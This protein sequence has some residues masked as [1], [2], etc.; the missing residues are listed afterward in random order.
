MSKELT[1]AD[2]LRKKYH[3]CEEVTN[4]K[5]MLDRSAIIFKTRT[6]FKLKDN[7]GKIY[8]KTYEELKN[9]VTELGTSLIE[10]GFLNKRI[11]VIGKNSYKWGISYLAAS[12]VGIVVPIDKELHSDDIINFMNVSKTECIL[13]DSKNLKQ[14]VENIDK[15][16]N[17]DTVFISFDEQNQDKKFIEIETELENGKKLLEN[18]NTKFDKIKINPDELRI[19]LFTSGTTGKA[20]GV[21]L[22]QRNI[23]SNILSTYG[24]VKVKR[25]DLFFSVLPMHHTYECSLGFLLPLYS[26]ASICFCEGLRYISDNMLEYHPSMILCVPLLLEKMYQKIVKNMQK[27]LPEKYTKNLKEKENI[28]DKLPFFLKEIVKLKVKNTL[29]GRLRLFIVGAAAVNPE[30]ADMFDKLGLN[31][32][33]GYGLTECAPL[34]AGNTDFYKRNDSA[35]L[36]I[37]NVEYK[38]KNPNE[39]GVGEIIVKG[40]NVMLGYYNMPEETE[41]VLKEGWFYTGDLG[42][43]DENGFLYITG[44][45]KSVIVTKNGKNIYPEELESY[46]SES[47]LISEALVLGVQK[48]NNDETYVNAQIFPNVEAITEY[49]KGAVPTKEEIKKIISDV[50]SSV[51]KKIPNYKHIKNFI[52]RDK[53]FEKTTTQ[54]I[55]RYGDN[56]KSGR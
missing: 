6:A 33:Q 54:K 37:P 16:E 45:C 30:I 31:S 32:L 46:L 49:L 29:G 25:S 42:K 47:P 23:C 2:K 19:L 26:G 8:N 7:E 51:N 48:E 35:G 34:V 12:I 4:F 14:I 22:S 40:P 56:M 18:G 10:K 27:S 1:I 55:K 39:E 41:K 11:A 44:R 15:L 53:E 43:I 28:I 20:K 36:P 24:I 9:E 5:E 3:K 13:G 21:C 50:V 17:K 38:I 52:I